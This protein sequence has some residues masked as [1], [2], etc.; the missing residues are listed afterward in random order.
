MG[1][2]DITL[3]LNEPGSLPT[4]WPPREGKKPNYAYLDH[5]GMPLDEGT[6]GEVDSN[7]A[8]VVQQYLGQEFRNRTLP[9][10]YGL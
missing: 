5:A 1:R 10:D 3:S 6:K 8:H 2:G 7:Q 4:K 9:E